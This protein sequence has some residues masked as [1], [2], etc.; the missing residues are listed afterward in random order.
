MNQPKKFML[1]KFESLYKEII[2][3]SMLMIA[4]R[5]SYLVKLMLINWD[6]YMVPQHPLISI[7]SP[8]LSSY[9]LSK[10]FVT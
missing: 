3:Y 2:K 5:T 7:F 10:H 9:I 1:L 6:L 4:E 8:N